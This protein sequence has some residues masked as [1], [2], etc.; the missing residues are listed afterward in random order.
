MNKTKIKE[1]LLPACKCRGDSRS[2]ATEFILNILPLPLG[3]GWGEGAISKE[4]G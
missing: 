3:E 2:E 1:N 4:P